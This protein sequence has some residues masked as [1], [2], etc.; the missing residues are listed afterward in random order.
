M[1]RIGQMPIEVPTGV[2]VEVR[3]SRVDVKG[4]NG[5]LTRDLPV[6]IEAKVE[7]G[8]VLVTRSGDGRKEKSLHGLS[9]TLLANMVEGVQK[10]FSKALEIEGVGF[11]AT[12]QGQKLALALGFA[13]PI[14][15]TVPAGVTVT[16][17]GGTNITVS[18]PDKQQVGDVAARIRS[19]FPAEPYKGKGLR[20]K[21][22]RIRRKVGKTVA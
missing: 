12:V 2:T 22:E 3:G 4:P 5:E 16:E 1:S 9:R 10:G 13:S 15:F 14:Q 8:K 21:G 17:K 7:D 20:Y 19:F 18:G 6:S 11:K